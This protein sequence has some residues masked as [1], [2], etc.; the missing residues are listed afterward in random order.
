M[1]VRKHGL[2]D[3]RAIER[4]DAW[5][6]A[7]RL[8]HT[9]RPEPNSGLD[10]KFSVQYCVARALLEGRIV[11]EHFEGDASAIQRYDAAAARACGAAQARSVRA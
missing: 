2:F 5:T 8:A 4:I 11:F 7:R 1:L 3:P 10:A 6:P 9:N